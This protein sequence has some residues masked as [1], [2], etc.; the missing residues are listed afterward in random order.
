[1]ISFFSGI[2][3]DSLH[4]TYK[5]DGTMDHETHEGHSHGGPGASNGRG[6]EQQHKF[7]GL[8]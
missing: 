8:S 1:M 4:C 6:G 5:F 2:K 7:F 3:E